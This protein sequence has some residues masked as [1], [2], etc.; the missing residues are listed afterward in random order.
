[1]SATEFARASL[2]WKTTKEWRWSKKNLHCNSNRTLCSLEYWFSLFCGAALL[3]VRLRT[4]RVVYSV[5]AMQ[6]ELRAT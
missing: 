1:M 3:F 2:A 4:R 6:D 5:A